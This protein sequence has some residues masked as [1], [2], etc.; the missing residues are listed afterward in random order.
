MQRKKKH[1]ASN[2]WPVYV[3]RSCAIQCSHHTQRNRPIHR[4]LKQWKQQNHTWL[5]TCRGHF[6]KNCLGP[7]PS[8]RTETVLTKWVRADPAIIFSPAW[9][10]NHKGEA[11]VCGWSG[12]CL[13][14]IA[15]WRR[16]KRTP[17]RRNRAELALAGNSRWALN[18][19]IYAPHANYLAWPDSHT[20]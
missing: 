1:F 4:Q 6:A 15:V 12:R 16:R 5:A 20:C 3:L 8:L 2:H 17:R 9:K 14:K 13:V 18:R 19:V 7:K 11:A 10:C